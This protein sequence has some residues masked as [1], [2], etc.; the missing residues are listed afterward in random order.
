[1]ADNYIEKRMEELREG[2]ASSATVFNNIDAI[3]VRSASAFEEDTSYAVHQLQVA[4][5]IQAVSRAGLGEVRVSPMAPSC[6]AFDCDNAVS[7]G[8][9][10]QTAVLK[11]FSMGLAAEVMAEAGEHTAV[12]RI[13]KKK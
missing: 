9:A 12:V 4:S 5:V 7:A 13:F 6:I 8:R 11:A 10:V 2:G 3:I 1:M